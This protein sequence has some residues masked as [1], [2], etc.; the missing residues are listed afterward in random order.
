MNPVFRD[1][2]FECVL[3]DLWKPN[4]QYNHNPVSESKDNEIELV[5]FVKG[6][7]EQYIENRINEINTC[8]EHIDRNNEMDWKVLKSD[9]N[10]YPRHINVSIIGT[11]KG[12]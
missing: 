1:K 12:K 9:G 8:L 3:G 6:D 7:E 11:G 4:K 5:I 10:G 2:L